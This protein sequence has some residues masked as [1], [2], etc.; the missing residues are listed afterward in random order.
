MHTQQKIKYKKKGNEL[1]STALGVPWRSPIQVLTEPDVAS[2]R[3]SD[4]NRCF[5]RGMAVDDIG[6]KKI[7]AINLM[8][9]LKLSATIMVGLCEGSQ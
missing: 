4:E 1:I 6:R 9:T 3:G 8:S 5:Q 2:L 7:L